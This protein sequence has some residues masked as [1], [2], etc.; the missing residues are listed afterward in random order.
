MSDAKAL[1][2]QAE[3]VGARYL[4]NCASQEYFGAVDRKTLKLTVLEPV[5]LEEKDGDAKI[6]SFF[7]K[8][9]RGAMARY[10]LE[11]RIADPYDLRGF[12]LDGMTQVE[13]QQ[14]HGVNHGQRL[15]RCVQFGGQG[16]GLQRARE[17]N[18]TAGTRGDQD[19]GKGG[20][21]IAH[22]TPRDLANGRTESIKTALS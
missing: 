7:A 15:F 6:V 18:I 17:I 13:V 9:A 1:D 4:L 10:A 21:E 8:R 19:C 5:F 11:N 14:A 22:G 20:Q 16:R 12:D 3:E 2:A